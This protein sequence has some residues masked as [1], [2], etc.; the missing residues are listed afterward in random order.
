MDQ[1]EFDLKIKHDFISEALEMLGWVEDQ[2]LIFEQDP[3]DSKV[4][5]DIFRMAH[6]IKGSAMTCGFTRLGE[7]A[8]VMEA[9][10]VKIREGKH[11]PDSDSVDV[12]LR[13][14]DTIRSYL[15]LL[16]QDFDAMLDTEAMEDEL[17]SFLGETTPSSS[18]LS[19]GSFG[20][21]DDDEPE[22][23]ATGGTGEKTSAGYSSLNPDEAIVGADERLGVE[24]LAAT[25]VNESLEEA[26]NPLAEASFLCLKAYLDLSSDPS[27]RGVTDCLSTLEKA[28]E[29]L[30]ILRAA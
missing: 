3:T 26:E 21:F 12:L 13:A 23:V 17:R 22:T 7:F 14:N 20:F 5:D 16:R 28:L 25:Y 9:L 18:P 19:A 2:F 11:Q 10:L 30:R 1:D 8:H 6:T 4:V 27:E 24:A 29:Q 15:E